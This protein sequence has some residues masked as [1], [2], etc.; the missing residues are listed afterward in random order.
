MDRGELNY[1]IIDRNATNIA[2]SNP[3]LVGHKNELFSLRP[4]LVEQAF[5]GKIV[6]V[7]PV[8]LNNPTK[9]GQSGNDDVL[10]TMYFAGPLQSSKGRVVAVMLQQIDPSK[11]FSKILQFSRV[12][13]SGES[14][15][16]NV[17]GRLLSESRFDDHLREIGLIAAKDHGILTIEIRDPG[18]NMV[19]GFRPTII[20]AE[21]PLT[22]MA[23][24]AIAM[25]GK[26]MSRDQSFSNIA[27]MTD[28]NGYNDYRGVPV[29]GAWLWDDELGFGITSEMD[30]AEALSPYKA[31]RLTV[32]GILT[33]T[34]LILVGITFFV[35]LVGERTNRILLKARD[36]LE[37][38]VKERTIELEENQK[39]LEQS[40]ERS[41]LL[42]ESVGEGIFG[43]GADGLVN[44]INP[45][46]LA[47]VGYEADEI[48][49]KEIH[50]IIHHSHEDKSS[51]PVEECPMYESFT[52]G[53][54]NSI[55]DEVLWRKDN[56]PFP[57]EYTS[58][59][60][61][62]NGDILGSVVVFRDI[63]ERKETE[64]QI[65]RAKDIAESA[66]KAKSDFLA[67]MSHEIR[68]PM[69]A[70]I[71]LSDLCLRT[72][73]SS[74]QED[75][76]TKI[77]SSANSL[78]GI[79]ND[80]L[81]FSKIE[82][83]KLDMES[84]PFE[85]DKTLSNVATIISIKAQEA[86]VELLFARHPDVPRHIIGDPLRLGQILTNLCNN[87][88][89]F[90]ED[91]EII[92]GIAPRE[93]SE[94][95]C[96]LEF[97]V[98][99]SGIGMTEEQVGRLFQSFSQ[100]DT[101]TTRK[102]GGTGLGLAISKQLVELMGGEIWVESEPE[103]GSTFLFTAVFEIADKLER[104]GL[105]PSPDLRGI[106]VL[107]IDDNENAR[108]ILSDYLT[109]FSFDVEQASSGEEGLAIMQKSEEPFML[110]MLDYMMPGLNGVET[111][112]K[113]REYFSETDVKLILVSSLNHDEYAD[114]PDIGVLD[115][116]LSK[117]TNPSLLFD[118]IME[119]FGKLDKAVGNSGRA[120]EDFDE[121]ALMVIRGARILL[122]EDNKINQQ[123]AT[124]LLEQAGFLVDIAGNGLES[125]EM[126]EDVA[127]DCLLMDVQMPVMD[128]YT[129]TGKIREIDK[130]ATL[131]ILAMTANALA[132]DKEQAIQS[133]M[134]DHIT[135]PI[136]PAQLFTALINWIK[137]G[138][139]MGE[140][141]IS[142][143]DIRSENGELPSVLPGIDQKIGVKQVG[144]NA[145]L[146]KKLLQDFFTDHRDDVAAIKKSFDTGD[147]L[148]GQRLAHTLKGV[149][150]TI[151]A[152]DLQH[153]AGAVEE[154]FRVKSSET[155][156]ETFPAFEIAIN[157]VITGLKDIV[158]HVS[159]PEMDSPEI[160]MNKQIA[161]LERLSTMLEEMDPDAEEVAGKLHTS[162]GK[163]QDYKITTNKL[164]NQVSG[165]E[166]EDA[167]ETLIE[168]RRS[169]E[170]KEN[171]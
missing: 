159:E 124:E 141:E 51:Y 21:Q 102:Y 39:Q 106:K 20:R 60:I 22:L 46:A 87:A 54:K 32:V 171:G 164:L 36:E 43:V 170:G 130:F 163:L 129:A 72:E 103:K 165:F 71:G 76:L 132:E 138:E 123:V 127:Y 114:H 116:Y 134:N 120:G 78:L 30:V 98:Q 29:V 55:A 5:Q 82:A 73:L 155:V 12:G 81:D 15:A 62:K 111:A 100:A 42:L 63:T 166:F 137:P 33:L 37:D 89:K 27:I 67:N 56:T 152:V 4:E 65:K 157:N 148:D 101:S 57:V 80:I 61:E 13:E 59:P 40:E 107:V 92:I 156:L 64:L 169:I 18:G 31:M 74:K 94:Q 79:I 91:G 34:L 8:H 70:V 153:A 97:R 17:E 108:I 26:G 118:V 112:I 50:P 105:Q 99:D 66:T 131:P 113:I 93:I 104:A 69:N 168:L 53:V 90:T 41:R 110:V 84:I 95:S 25:K 77:H 151:G 167:Q 2:A 143:P 35:L 147:Y 122:V 125:L 142:Q 140:A 119:V 52:L 133:G 139:H 19:E 96:T 49:D 145:S 136:N 11:G 109:Q 75:Y 117:P 48:L 47:M 14:Y 88:V 38:K 1:L 45:A 6:F 86:G 3:G 10:P 58:V 121:S 149:G 23:R 150:G 161:D 144:G 135:K 146:Y 160:D 128:G 28:L 115:N 83:G 126:I 44:F 7:P 16:F 162:L 85:L 24:N 9:H 68:T 154:A 158:V